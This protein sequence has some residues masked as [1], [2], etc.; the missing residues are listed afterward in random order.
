MLVD[1][2]YFP[3]QFRRVLSM[4]LQPCVSS[5]YWVQDRAEQFCDTCS[6]EVTGPGVEVFNWEVRRTQTRWFEMRLVEGC[7]LCIACG[8]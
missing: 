7:G 5:V 4:V 3:E 2:N 6:T 1:L 8:R